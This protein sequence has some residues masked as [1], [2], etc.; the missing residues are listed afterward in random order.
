MKRLDRDV[1]A[2]EASEAK[3]ESGHRSPGHPKN[4]PPEP[5]PTYPPNDVRTIY[6]R[7][8][9]AWCEQAD[10]RDGVQGRTFAVIWNGPEIGFEIVPAWQATPAMTLYTSRA[11]PQHSGRRKTWQH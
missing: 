8:F 11:K 4:P 7:R 6:A 5:K 10:I 2:V 9:A 3:V 1:Y